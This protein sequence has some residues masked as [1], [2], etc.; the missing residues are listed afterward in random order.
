MKRWTLPLIALLFLAC[1]GDSGPAEEPVEE[2]APA[3]RVSGGDA[4]LVGPEEAEPNGDGAAPREPTFEGVA[5]MAVVRSEDWRR[6]NEYTRMF[7]DGELEALHAKFS[8]DAK[9]ELPL[10]A[11][12]ALRDQMLQEL[13]TELQP[14][15]FKREEN[16]G[17]R[18]YKRA[19]KFSEREDLVEVAWVIAPDDS[20]AG[21]FISPQRSSKE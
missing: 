14:L 3:P 21:L 15:A 1:A 18:A 9:T 7:Y 16:A 4:P 12:T 13:G 11:L 17:Y 10:A 20:I 8:S 2:P 19:A 6:V 5:G